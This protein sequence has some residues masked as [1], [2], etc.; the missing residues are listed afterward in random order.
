MGADY[1]ACIISCM[2]TLYYNNYIDAVVVIANYV[3]HVS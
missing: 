3:I 2:Y 1:G